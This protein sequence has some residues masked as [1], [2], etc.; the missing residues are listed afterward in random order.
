MAFGTSSTSIINSTN[1]SSINTTLSTN[2]NNPINLTGS[3]NKIISPN[4]INSTSLVNLVNITDLTTITSSINK[5]ISTNVLSYINLTIFFNLTDFISGTTSINQ[6][7]STNIINS[8]YLP[9]PFNLIDSTNLTNQAKVYAEETHCYALPYRGTGFPTNIMTFYTIIILWYVRRPLVPWRTL[10]EFEDGKASLR[11]FR[12]Q[13]GFV[14]ILFT[15]IPAIVTMTKCRHAWYE[16]AFSSLFFSASLNLIA[17][18]DIQGVRSNC[19]NEVRLGPRL[20]S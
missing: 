2:I 4:T 12:Q 16:T 18:S 5:T 15:K 20:W 3:I 13:A 1:I 17:Y 8:T 7:I 11:T 6:T 10:D 14:K 19:F 9:D